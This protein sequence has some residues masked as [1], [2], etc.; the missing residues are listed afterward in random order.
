MKG[1]SFDKSNDSIQK[2]YGRAILKEFPNY[3]MLWS[4][5]IGEIRDIKNN[6][7][8]SY[9]LVF[10]T[11]LQIGKRRYIG[12]HYERFCMAHYAL[13]CNLAGAHYQLE[14]MKDSLTINDEDEKYFKHWECFETCYSHLEMAFYQLYHMWGIM[15]L[16]RGVG[17]ITEDK[18]GRLNG[19]IKHALIKFLSTRSRKSI[20]E[21]NRLDE[22]IKALRDNTTHFARVA[23]IYIS[24][25]YYI[26]YNIMINI[27][28]NRQFRCRQWI[29]TT[30]RIESD[31]ISTE[32][33]LNRIHPFM[34]KELDD[35]LKS[36][37]IKINK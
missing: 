37:N 8:R 21:I 22:C 17:K 32:R 23:S 12:T 2:L 29:E 24:G 25:Q 11:Q 27:N 13:F 14:N 4:K 5:F 1:A 36:K 31:L 35:F 30:K 10:P 9:G 3:E 33:L 19:S 16:L 15:F 26:P 28:W 34:T 7:L 20:K 6:R 18:E